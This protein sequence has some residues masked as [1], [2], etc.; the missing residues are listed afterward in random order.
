MREEHLSIAVV[1]AGSWGMAL[2]YVLSN[3]GHRVSVFT[4]S[5]KHAEEFARLHENRE[6]LPGVILKDTVSFSSDLQEVVK[7]KDV[8][9]M[10]VPSK[11]IRETAREIRPILERE[12]SSSQVDHQGLSLKEEGKREGKRPQIVNCTKGIEDGSLKTMSEVLE[13]ELPGFA[14]SVLSGPSHAEEVGKGMPTTIVVGAKTLANARFLQNVFMNETFRVYISPDMLGIELGASLK[15]VIALGAGI[16]DGLG[17]GDNTRAALITRGIYE[18]TKLGMAMGGEFMTFTG[19]SGIGDLIVTCTSE[20]SRN[21]RAGKRIGQGATPEE[22][23]REVKQVVEGVFSAKAALDLSRKYQVP[24]PIVE[25]VNAVLFQGK[26][27]EESVRDLMLRDKKAESV[28]LVWQGS[29]EQ[30]EY[31]Q[32]RIR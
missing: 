10:V 29:E 25:E 3:N 20:H 22:A 30:K 11:T 4:R 13:E 1:G 2:A 6:K 17:Y 32:F 14:I 9:V 21:H 15:N 27:P 18:I 7:Q 8:I 24:M 31:Q 5:A 19:L 16:A 28:S 26:S 12:G 23:M